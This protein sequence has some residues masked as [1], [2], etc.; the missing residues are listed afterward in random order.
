MQETFAKLESA[1]REQRQ[2]HERDQWR[3]SQE[4]ARVQVCVCAYGLLLQTIRRP[5]SYLR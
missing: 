1:L 5:V 2:Q 3:V 4:A